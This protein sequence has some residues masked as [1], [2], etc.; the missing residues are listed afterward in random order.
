M[1]EAILTGHNNILSL[2]KY[3]KHVLQTYKESTIKIPT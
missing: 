1:Q 2:N 3:C